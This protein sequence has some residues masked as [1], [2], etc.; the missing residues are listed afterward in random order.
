MIQ[1]T[2]VQKWSGSSTLATSD[3]VLPPLQTLSFQGRNSLHYQQN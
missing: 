2:Q 3:Q 1:S